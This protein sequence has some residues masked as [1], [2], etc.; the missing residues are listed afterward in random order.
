MVLEN[1]F[2]WSLLDT[3]RE[4]AMHCY[5]FR[6]RVEPTCCVIVDADMTRSENIK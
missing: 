1:K 5:V 6:N 2:F 4:R 3:S